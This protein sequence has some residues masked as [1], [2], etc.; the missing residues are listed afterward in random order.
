MGR[1]DKDIINKYGNKSSFS[2]C[3]YL[4][5]CISL[6]PVFIIFVSFGIPYL[7]CFK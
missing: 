5:Y 3:I 6:W 4:V 7:Q 2:F 1:G